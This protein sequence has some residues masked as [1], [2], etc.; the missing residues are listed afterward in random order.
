MNHSLGLP[1][2]PCLCVVCLSGP[3]IVNWLR[4]D[5]TPRDEI[6]TIF[7][8]I[9]QSRFKPSF[10]PSLSLHSH[11]SLPRANLV[12]FDYSGCLAVIFG[13]RPSVGECGRL[14]QAF[15]RTNIVLLTYL[16]F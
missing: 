6:S 16:V 10:S 11:L 4:D 14:S 1:G 9:F 2:S 7:F 12:K 15:G 3:D 5:Y 8:D 13:G